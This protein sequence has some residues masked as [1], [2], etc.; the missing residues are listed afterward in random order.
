MCRP[1][2]E[3]TEP[4]EWEEEGEDAPRESDCRRDD[5]AKT[6]AEALS[7]DGGTPATAGAKVM[8]VAAAG[9]AERAAW[10]VV[11]RRLGWW[12]CGRA[13][14][15]S[16]VE[17]VVEG[18]EGQELGA[19]A[20]PGPEAPEQ[21]QPAKQACVWRLPSLRQAGVCRRRREG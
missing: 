10:P 1:S 3:T 19:P 15:A 12:W 4:P 5:G 16:G 7:T 9:A 13:G 17:G 18:V 14:L 8:A 6:L 20:E 11:F 2:R 21:P